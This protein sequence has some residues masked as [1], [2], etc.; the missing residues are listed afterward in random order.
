MTAFLYATLIDNT[1]KKLILFFE[2]PPGGKNDEPRLSSFGRLFDTIRVLLNYPRV[3]WRAR[4]L[5]KIKKEL[6]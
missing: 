2:S 4:K 1:L 6:Q 3:F 5:A